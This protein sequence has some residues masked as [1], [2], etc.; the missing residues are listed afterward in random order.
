M[1]LRMT[2]EEYVAL[3]N[4]RKIGADA[5]RTQ[6]K[7]AAEAK[8]TKYGNRRTERDGEVFD[9]RHEAEAYGRLTLETRAGEHV[10]L[11][12]QVAFRLPGGVTY[13]ADFVTL[14]R[15]GRYAVWDAKSAATARDK[16]YRIKKRLMRE[17]L[18]LEIREV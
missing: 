6:P 18:G 13:L 5:R 16:V 2:E 12:R 11:L 7:P 9:S 8:R 10:Q 14:E 17:C 1:S 4:R 15:D 3:M